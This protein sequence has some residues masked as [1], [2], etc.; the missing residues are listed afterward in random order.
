M[1]EAS[2]TPSRDR[3]NCLRHCHTLPA[4]WQ[5]RPQGTTSGLRKIR[6]DP[7][8]RDFSFLVLCQDSC[9]PPSPR[10]LP[11]ASQV[12]LTSPQV[13]HG[14]VAAASRF[15]P[16]QEPRKTVRVCK[17]LWGIPKGNPRAPFS[18][19]CQCTCTQSSARQTPPPRHDV[20]LSSS[21]LPLA[22]VAR[23][24]TV[25]E[26]RQERST[27]NLTAASRVLLGEVSCH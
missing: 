3:Q 12:T 9:R 4:E 24:G 8:V 20:L 11:L 5:N 19:I 27:L 18:I 25:A 13:K 7:K 10:L 14:G 16:L 15:W 6:G 17:R 1:P 23:V 21:V 22:T 26:G 2:P